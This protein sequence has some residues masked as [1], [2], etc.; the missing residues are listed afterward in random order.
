[1]TIKLLLFFFKVGKEPVCLKVVLESF[2]EVVR[3]MFYVDLNRYVDRKGVRMPLP[4]VTLSSIIGP[5]A[6]SF[7][8]LKS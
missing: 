3:D 5:S 4:V 1:M 2:I 8:R 7:I 6:G